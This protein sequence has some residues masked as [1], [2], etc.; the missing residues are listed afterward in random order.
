MLTEAPVCLTGGVC[1]AH[2]LAI[3]NDDCTAGQAFAKHY[4]PLLSGETSH[5]S[6]HSSDK[7]SNAIAFRRFGEQMQADSQASPSSRMPGQSIQTALQASSQYAAPTTQAMHTNNITSKVKTEPSEEQQEDQAMHPLPK[8]VAGPVLTAE[9]EVEGT[10]KQSSLGKQLGD[11]LRLRNWKPLEA[12]A[13]VRE[14]DQEPWL[15]NQTNPSQIP[16]PAQ[17]TDAKVL[18]PRTESALLIAASELGF[19]AQQDSCDLQSESRRLTAAAQPP[20]DPASA[21]RS[22][23]K[24]L[25]SASAHPCCSA[26]QSLPITSSTLNIRCSLEEEGALTSSANQ[27]CCTDVPGLFMIWSQT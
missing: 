27:L 4:N 24:C 21:S 17:M 13:A 23:Q 6:Q 2:A 25:T 19:D 20:N 1:S 26:C 15:A 3:K 5:G 16:Q 14:P 8:T 12:P 7:A 9:A 22:V 11:A 18:S 10:H